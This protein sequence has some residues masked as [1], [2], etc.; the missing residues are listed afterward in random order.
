MRGAGDDEETWSLGLTPEMFHHHKDRL[1]G[2][3]GDFECMEMVKDIVAESSSSSNLNVNENFCSVGESGIAIST[4]YQ[5]GF[6]FYI[7]L[8]DSTDSPGMNDNVLILESVVPKL[9]SA[10]IPALIT[11]SSSPP[12]K[13]LII[14]DDN[15]WTIGVALSLILAHPSRLVDLNRSGLEKAVVTR[16]V[17]VIQ[18]FVAGAQPSRAR[19][20]AV[21]KWY[22]DHLS[23]FH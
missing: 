5:A 12:C 10:Q 6:D 19:V 18:G 1:L 2:C 13:I 8:G 23:K 16:L 15:D 11:S 3:G 14:G 4:A 17:F 7:R 9:F 21:S 22:G 20:K